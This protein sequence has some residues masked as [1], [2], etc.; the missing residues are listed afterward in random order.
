MEAGEARGLLSR[1]RVAK[2]DA[3]ANRKGKSSPFN[4]KQSK[5]L[6]G[7]VHISRSPCTGQ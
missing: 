2:L 7:Y 6:A 5:S 1:E 4:K 3:H